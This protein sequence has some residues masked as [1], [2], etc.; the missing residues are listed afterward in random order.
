MGRFLLEVALQHTLEGN[1]V[2]GLVPGHLVDGVVDGIQA[3][4]LGAVSQIHLTCGGAE[5][6]VRKS[7]RSGHFL[8]QTP[9]SP[10]SPLLERHAQTM[11][12]CGIEESLLTVVDATKMPH[13]GRSLLWQ[14]RT[15]QVYTS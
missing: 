10:I 5:L 4:A 14:N 3:V 11:P 15:I 2:T 13:F 1:T 9:T 6:A 8:R 7:V 12:H